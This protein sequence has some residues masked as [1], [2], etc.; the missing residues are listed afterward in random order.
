[1]MEDHLKKYQHAPAHLFLT[2]FCYFIT[3][4]TYSKKRYFEDDDKKKYL[5]E[6]ICDVFNAY[7][8][9]LHGWVI[10][11]NHYH[12]IGKFKDAFFLPEMIKKNHSKSAV[13][14][15]KSAEKPGRKIWYQYWDECIRDERDYY[16][17]INYIHWNPVR[18]GYVDAP[19]VYKF[20]S[21]N[22]YLN[23]RG[24]EWLNGI[25]KRFPFEEVKNNDDY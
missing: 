17:K 18:H 2:D 8:S 24:E 13:W 3:A 10:L 1:M 6:T 19:R 20:S 9:T 25:L 16:T 23:F 15:N 22:S 11:G 5:Y 7:D 14:L 4:G 12:I 21:Y